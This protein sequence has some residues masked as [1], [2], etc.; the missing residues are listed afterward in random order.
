MAKDATGRRLAK[1]LEFILNAIS[2][3]HALNSFSGFVA[4]IT[5]YFTWTIW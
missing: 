5:N 1:A 2:A 3:A 4:I